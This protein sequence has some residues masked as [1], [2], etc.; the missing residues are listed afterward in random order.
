MICLN[1]VVTYLLSISRAIIRLDG[2]IFGSSDCDSSG[3]DVGR[4]AESSDEGLSF[5]GLQLNENV[6]PVEPPSFGMR[7]QVDL[8]RY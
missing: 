4:V 5:R 1:F 6:R 7:L 8:T 3:V 2:Q